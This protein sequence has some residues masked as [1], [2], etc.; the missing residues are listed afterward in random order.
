M[1]IDT[2][3][4]DDYAIL[5]LK[6]EFDTFHCPRFQ[7]EFEAT[8]EQDVAF[9]ILNMR[10]VK[11]I[12]S[13]A[14]GAIIKASKLCKSEEGELVISNPS[15]MVRDIINTLG[16]DQMVPVFDDEEAAGKHIIK[17]LNAVVLEDSAP[18][19]GEKVLISFPPGDTRNEQ[20][21]QKSLM[22]AS[23]PLVGTMGN[24]DGEKARFLWSGAKIGISAD[25]AEQLF[26]KNSDIH[27]KFQVKLIKK[28]HFE[29]GAQVQESEAASDGHIRITATFTKIR[30]NEREELAQ[31]ARDMRRFKD[32]LG[33]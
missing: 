12:N 17:Q 10:R 27:L 8:L 31:Y 15:R 13:T 33:D 32:E 30:E 28:D 18:V 19:R 14:L 20:I 22:G 25:Q 23:K 3:L 16:I 11:F 4:T 26:F 5:T 1:N 7:A 2:T 24:V 21:G 9:V 29:V 6:G